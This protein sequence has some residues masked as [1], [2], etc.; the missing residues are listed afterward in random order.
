MTKICFYC[1]TIFS[2]GGVQRVLAVIAKALS[3]NHE[4]T[5]LTYDRPEEED[6]SMY[7][8]GEAKIRFRY[9]SRPAISWWEYF[10]CKAYSFLY[11]KK[12]VPQTALT[13]QWYGYSSFPFSM[14][15]ELIE[16]LNN[17]NYDVII[18]VHA[19]LS[20]QLASIRHKLNA[21]KVIGWMHSS[22][23]AFFN[24][25][26]VY[27]YEQKNQFR[28]EMRK[29]DGIIVLTHRDREL[30]EQ[31]LQLFPKAIYNPLPL[32]P[33]GEGELSYKRFLSVGRM[34]TRAK[35]FDILI[36]AF[37]LFAREN[38]EWTLE[39]VGE[40]SGESALREQIN[41]HKLNDRVIISP[42]TKQIQ[43]HYTSSSVYILSSRWEGFCLVLPEAMSHRLPIICSDLPFIKELLKD[44]D[45]C[46]V[47]QNGNVEELAK[48][49]KEMAGLS[50]EQ[51]NRMGE[52]SL[53]VA[54]L[55]KLPTIL[56]EWEEYLATV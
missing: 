2:F 9:I 4:I 30:Y 6:R 14:R 11:K 15:K 41:R 36:E 24:P 18:G 29:L 22:F 50:P 1:D 21:S 12:V 37:A 55:L 46:L 39:I 44:K 25:P 7:E 54:E 38:N 40:G 32:T 27:L 43:K 56:K 35:G 49:M 45:N 31:E 34:S 26:G 51:F 42:F 52:T 10:P 28:H 19:F 48:R 47:F 33:D 53:E 20:L 3:P 16:E 13:S 23:D 17:E 5:I 8:L